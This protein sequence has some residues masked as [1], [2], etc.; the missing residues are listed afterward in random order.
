MCEG[1]NTALVAVAPPPRPACAKA[2]RK[3]L[4]LGRPTPPSTPVTLGTHQRPQKAP[5][6]AVAVS[7]AWP[8]LVS[9]WSTLLG[10]PSP[11]TALR[12]EV[13]YPAPQGCA[14]PNLRPG[15]PLA[16]GMPCWHPGLL[17]GKGVSAQGRPELLHPLEQLENESKAVGFSGFCF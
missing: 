13:S 4:Q 1:H 8:L 14:H 6:S 12:H 2:E 5:A 9:S 10:V 17:S 15:H 7:L 16:P 3:V 11:P